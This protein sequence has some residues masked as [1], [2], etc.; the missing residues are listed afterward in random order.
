MRIPLPLF[1]MPLLAALALGA[2]PARASPLLEE[3]FEVAQAGFANQAGAALRQIGLRAAA[4]EGALSTLLRQKQALENQRAEVEAQLAQDGADRTALFGV[5]DGLTAEVAALEAD[6]QRDHP[7]FDRITRPKA[8][9]VAQ[10][11]ALLAPDEALILTFVAQTYTYVWAVSPTRAGWHRVAAG[12]ATLDDVVTKLRSSLDPTAPARAAVALD[13]VGLEAVQ[14]SRNHAYLLYDYLLAPLEP[15]FEQAAHLFIVADGALTSLPFSL[16]VTAPPDGADDDPAAMRATPWLIRRHALTT[17]PSVEALGVVRAMPPALAGRDAFIGFGDPSFS[18][19]MQVAALTRG[20]LRAGAADVEQLRALA[21][22]PQTRKELLE[23]ARTLGAGPS[24]VRLGAAAT[25]TAVKSADLSRAKVLAFATHGL[26][27]GDLAGL[28]EPALVMSPP[29]SATPGDDGL[30]TASEIT[31]L[32]LDADWVVLSACNTAGGAAPG[33][34]G[35]SGL[36]RAFLFAG[37]RSILVSHW[38]VRDDA[39]ARLTTD[40]FARLGRGEARGKA[41]ALRGAMLSL[42]EDTRDPSLAFPSAWA[43]F[44]LVGEGQ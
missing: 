26:L 35:L 36:A 38:P 23:I 2:C 28:A 9:S 32:R 8:L 43:P 4:G 19:E 10:V 18:G 14:F 37:A 22:L 33:A 39:A 31:E 3:T 13:P 25:E 27:S 12:K 6:L 24:S 11:Q 42:M 16:L 17:L 7:E 1:I 29:Q 21:P 40:T 34:E 30:L 15:V 5:I 41:D 44:V 20:A